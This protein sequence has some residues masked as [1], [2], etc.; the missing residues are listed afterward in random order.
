MPDEIVIRPL[1]AEDRAEWEV[2][3]KGYQVFY[4]TDIP[5]EVTDLTWARFHDP[6][7]PMHALVLSSTALSKASFITSFT[8][9]A[10][11]RAITATCRI[12]LLAKMRVA[13]ASDAS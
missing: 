3:W 13:K 8:G 6:A 2:L 12:C 10:G 5:A 1:R 7:E 9:P 11:R 4:K